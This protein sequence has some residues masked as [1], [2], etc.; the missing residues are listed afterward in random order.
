[1][2]AVVSSG[3]GYT[4]ALNSQSSATQ[5]TQATETATA[6]EVE[7]DGYSNDLDGLS[8]Y[9]AKKGYIEVDDKGNIDKSY[10]TEMDY[11]LI[12][13]KSGNKYTVDMTTIELY[14]F[15]KTDGDVYKSVKE[16]GKFSILGLPEATAYLSDNGKFMMIYTDSTIDESKT[17]AD[18]YVKRQQIIDDFKVFNK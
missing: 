9:F 10:V 15:D 5:E 8:K 7:A 11:D 6:D 1:M 13:A 18:N 3:C 2:I 17:D 12:G 16:T 14:E 4:D